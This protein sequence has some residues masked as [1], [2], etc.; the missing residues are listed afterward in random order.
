M[1][2]EFP[3]LP[4]SLRRLSTRLAR[5]TFGRKAFICALM[6]II[7][8]PS[9][10]T[11]ILVQSGCSEPKNTFHVSFGSP[12][13]FEA[14]SITLM[15]DQNHMGPLQPLSDGSPLLVKDNES[16][17]PLS[18]VKEPKHITLQ[19]SN[20]KDIRNFYH[21]TYDIN[22][23]ILSTSNIHP[24]NVD[25]LDGLEE[26]RLTHKVGNKRKLADG[27]ET[28]TGDKLSRGER[29]TDSVSFNITSPR[30]VNT[31]LDLIPK[32]RNRDRDFVSANKLRNSVSAKLQTRK[33]PLQVT[34][35]IRNSYSS[36]LRT[37][38]RRHNDKKLIKV[39]TDS[40]NVHDTATF[41]AQVNKSK[42]QSRKEIIPL[43]LTDI[44]F[45]H[46]N[47]ENA[48]V[49]STQPTD[50]EHL[51]CMYPQYFVYT[52]VLCM[53]A[54]ASFLKLNYLVKT[55]VLV[56]MVACYGFLI[57]KFNSIFDPVYR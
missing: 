33:F 13:S 31:K 28:L 36:D 12:T 42:V 26:S 49:L 30:Y 37:R 27:S 32:F 39:K 46:L 19:T 48:T 38:M 23:P 7:S 41:D 9:M 50:P 34:N 4:T 44:A 40:T 24:G 6:A 20:I 3:R 17:F 8:V 10:L 52:W 56:F 35:H 1:A 29:A 21:T 54:L 18:L 47:L 22:F 15:E 45:E 43:D 55:M 53:V 57:I 11:L 16:D 14:S 25:Y 5:A 51:Y 2:E